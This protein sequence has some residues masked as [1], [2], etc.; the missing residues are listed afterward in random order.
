MITLFFLGGGGGECIKIACESKSYNAGRSCETIILFSVQFYV[1]SRLRWG[2]RAQWKGN[3]QVIFLACFRH[4]LTISPFLPRLVRPSVN[5][6][7][8]WLST[9]FFFVPCT[10]STVCHSPFFPACPIPKII[11]RRYIPNNMHTL[12]T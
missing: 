4:H 11:L 1:L 5:Q 2:H 9:C 10:L 7:D 3:N 8:Q 12:I 6:V